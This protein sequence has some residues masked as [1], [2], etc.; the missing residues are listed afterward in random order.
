MNIKKLIVDSY[1]IPLPVPVK[2]YAAGLMTGFDIV[3]V[4]ITD[5]NGNEGQGYTTGHSG[6]GGSIVRIIKDSFES[7]L[8]GEDSARIEYLWLKMWKKT[9]YVGR[10]GQASF[11]ISAVD[12]ALWDLLGKRLK[13][14]LW[15]LLGGYSP[16]VKVYAGNIDLN[17]PIEQILDNAT[18]NIE[19]GFKAIKMRLGRDTLKEDLSRVEAMR[20]HIGDDIELM[21]DANEAWRVDQALKASNEL[22][23]FNLTWLEEP[24]TPDDFRGYAYLKNNGATPIAAGENLHTLKEFQQLFYY[25]GVDFPEPDYTTCGGFTPFMKIA[26]LAE[27]YNLPV[28][29]H[30]AH[31]V[32]VHL[33]AA[34][35][36]AAYIEVHAFG[37]EEYISNP[38]KMENGY[39]IAP[40]TPGIGFKFN[41][42]KLK[43]FKAN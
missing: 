28:M 10:G 20:N 4:R 3:V 38:L 19:D 39:G 33:L 14:P 24:I 13:Q 7:I 37:I 35:P 32:H 5:E 27:A 1:T 12:A 16:K 41:F 17:F 6:F 8:I 9:H 21:A 34:C 31:D 23:N 18:K 42:D 26:K 30:G 29:S 15:K 43:E 40:D 11:A 25:D 22:A 36:N 2:A